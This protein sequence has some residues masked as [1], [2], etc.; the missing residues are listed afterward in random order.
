MISVV[1]LISEKTM[2]SVHPINE[3][4]SPTHEGGH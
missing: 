1:R 3:T 4:N 2:I